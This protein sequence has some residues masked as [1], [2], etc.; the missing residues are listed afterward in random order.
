VLLLLRSNTNISCVTNL[1]ANVYYR[2]DVLT[3]FRYAKCLHSLTTTELCSLRPEELLRIIT[4]SCG[5]FDSE[6]LSKQIATYFNHHPECLSREVLDSLTDESFM[7]IISAVVAL[8]LLKL[9]IQHAED[10]QP[11]ALGVALSSM[12]S[13]KKRCVRACAANWEEALGTASFMKAMNVD[14]NNN[15]GREVEII[16]DA[17]NG[18]ES[19]KDEFLD[20]PD[21]LKVEILQLA[22]TSCNHKLKQYRGIHSSRRMPS[23]EEDIGFRR[24]G[25]PRIGFMLGE[26]HRRPPDI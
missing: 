18:G 19:V 11:S 1:I 6:T 25:G 7:P 13:L 21:S 4:S 9:A 16:V 3:F 8:P 14:G 26:R 15:N 17:D 5:V 10:E 23:V 24:R 2:F 22:L 12:N 20:L